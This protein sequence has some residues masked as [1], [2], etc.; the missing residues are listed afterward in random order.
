MTEYTAL[1]YLL[2]D[3]FASENPAEVRHNSR[4]AD[5]CILELAEKIKAKRAKPA[6]AETPTR[7]RLEESNDDLVLTLIRDG[8]ELTR[9]FP[10]KGTNFYKTDDVSQMAL[11]SIKAN[12]GKDGYTWYMCR[13][14]LAPGRHWSEMEKTNE[15]LE[16]SEGRIL[17][18]LLAEI[19]EQRHLKAETKARLKDQAF[20]EA[21]VKS[22][23]Y[24][25]APVLLNEYA[26]SVKSEPKSGLRRTDYDGLVYE[27]GGT[28]LM[29]G[30]APLLRS[31]CV[32]NYKE[33]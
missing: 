14:Y 7:P 19:W 31:P 13:E 16:P 29:R 3:V 20:A 8:K 9:T 28:A 24:P 17:F 32:L 21:A 23:F 18:R 11:Q 2:Q 1:N 30:P 12:P 33:V 10:I 27:P 6:V 25:P 22:A 5:D 15:T 26:A 4:A